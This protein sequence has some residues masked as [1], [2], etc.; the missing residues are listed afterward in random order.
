MPQNKFLPTF[1]DKKL[2]F[3]KKFHFFFTETLAFLSNILY[4]KTVV[5]PPDNLIISNPKYPF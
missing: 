3:S 2:I 4:N 1:S 5:I